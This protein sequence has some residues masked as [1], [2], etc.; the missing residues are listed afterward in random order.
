MIKDDVIEAQPQNEPAPWVPNSVIVNK[1]DGDLRVVIDARK[2]NT[3]LIS[4][5]HPD[6]ETIY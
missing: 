4:T 3:A 1:E 6:S 5:N 2:P